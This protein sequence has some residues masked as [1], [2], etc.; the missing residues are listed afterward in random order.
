MWPFIHSCMVTVATGCA[1]GEIGGV[2]RL[3]GWGG[4]RHDDLVLSEGSSAAWLF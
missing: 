3:I 1:R 4:W 2:A